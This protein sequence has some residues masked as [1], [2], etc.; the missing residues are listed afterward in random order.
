[1]VSIDDQQEVLHEL[2]TESILEPQNSRW[3]TFAILKIAKSPYPNENQGYS[4]ISSHFSVLH[5]QRRPNFHEFLY[6]I[7]VIFTDT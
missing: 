2:F 7:F 6:V 1:M 3:Q 4:I 5:F